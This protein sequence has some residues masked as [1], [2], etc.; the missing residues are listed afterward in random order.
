[1]SYF[2]PYRIEYFSPRY[3]KTVI[4]PIGYESDGASGPAVDVWSEA[5]WI[6]DRLCDTG[7]WAD[8][9]IATNWQA[10]TVLAD[11]LHYEGRWFRARTWWIATWLFGC[12]RCAKNGR[13]PWS[14][15]RSA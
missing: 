3:R 13:W 6:H 14:G 7:R 9:S 11:I 4:V 8:G 1:L 5:W 2:C 10:S 15:K 12:K